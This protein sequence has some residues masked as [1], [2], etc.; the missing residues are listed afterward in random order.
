LVN[1]TLAT[2]NQRHLTLWPLVGDHEAWQ[3]TARPK[4]NQANGS[5]RHT[6]HEL[7]GV[8]N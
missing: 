4:I 3:P 6:G 2:V 5:M 8:L 1:P 7:Q